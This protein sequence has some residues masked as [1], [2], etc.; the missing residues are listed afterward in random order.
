[1]VSEP[2]L[3]VMRMLPISFFILRLSCSSALRSPRN[4]AWVVISSFAGDLE[5][6]LKFGVRIVTTDAFAVSTPYT[7]GSRRGCVLFPRFTPFGG[8]ES[9]ALLAEQ[10][11][12]FD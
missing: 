12:A 7:H 3:G 10:E 9:P 8:S 1:M 4:C 2:G 5:G 6:N 11:S